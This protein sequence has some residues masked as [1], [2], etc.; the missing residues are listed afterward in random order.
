VPSGVLSGNASQ[1][2]SSCSATVL[3]PVASVSCSTQI[4]LRWRGDET[5]TVLENMYSFGCPVKQDN[6]NA[7]LQIEIDGV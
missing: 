6:K 2:E 1:I 4:Q 5:L 7:V 3:Q